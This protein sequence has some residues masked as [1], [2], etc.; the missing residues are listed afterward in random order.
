LCLSTNCGPPRRV[1]QAWLAHLALVFDWTAGVVV[2]SGRVYLRRNSGMCFCADRGRRLACRI[3]SFLSSRRTH[4]SNTFR[5]N[6]EERKGALQV[7][8]TI[9]HLSRHQEDTPAG[10]HKSAQNH[11]TP[12]LAKSWSCQQHATYAAASVS[13]FS[14]YF[15]QFAKML[16]I[17]GEL[18]SLYTSSKYSLVSANGF[19]VTLGMYFPTSFEGSID[20]L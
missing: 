13:S 16:P 9:G 11:Q 7:S 6:S 5:R 8:T 17:F 12:A 14:S 4:V 10:Y 18:V 1:A 15:S 20:V 3:V 19:A 2:G